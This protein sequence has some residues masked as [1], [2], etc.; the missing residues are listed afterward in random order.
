MKLSIAV[1][2]FKMSTSMEVKLR[3]KKIVS[4]SVSL[5]RH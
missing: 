3:E 5:L 1:A 2:L 4:Q